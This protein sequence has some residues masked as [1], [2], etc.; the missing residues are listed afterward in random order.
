MRELTASSGQW[1]SDATVYTIEVIVTSGSGGLMASINYG[2]QNN[3]TPTFVNTYRPTGGGGGGGGTPPREIIDE[4]PPL[5]FIEDHV[6]YV[7]GYPDNTVR[8]D[9]DITRAEVATVFFRLL[10]DPR[11][12]ENWTQENVFTD[13]Q[14]SHWYNNA[15][16]VMS[17][18]QILNGYPDGTFKPDNSITRGELAAIAARFARVTRITPINDLTFSDVSGHWAERDI[19]FA[20][21]VGWVNGYPDGTFRPDQ[22]I[23]RAEFMTLANRMLERVPE[24]IQDI[25]TD[26]MKQWVDNA[27]TTRWYYIAVQEAS[28]SHEAEYKED[29]IVPGLDFEYEFWTEMMPNRDW[30][31]LEKTW[32]TAYS[33]D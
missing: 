3:A 20:A 17:R 12:I 29:K 5:V 7:I 1:T 11:R 21:S 24:T 30:A 13:V 8:P 14:S 16:S 26:E 4:D 6:A 15:V 31:Q 9:R 27:E 10:A 33:A 22:P 28:N 19:Q 23:T 25:L 18:M 32:S 2:T